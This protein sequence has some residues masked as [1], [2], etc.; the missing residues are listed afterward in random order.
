MRDKDKMGRLSKDNGYFNN[1]DTLIPEG[2]GKRTRP[3][4][5]QESQGIVGTRK[6]SARS[7]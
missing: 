6:E 4:S 1:R 2:K 5:R 7:P 3:R